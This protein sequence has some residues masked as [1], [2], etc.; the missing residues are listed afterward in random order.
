MIRIIFMTSSEEL[1]TVESSDF[2]PSII[3]NEEENFEI[4]LIAGIKKSLKAYK[5]Q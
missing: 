2:E 1:I 5:K 4:N 3:K